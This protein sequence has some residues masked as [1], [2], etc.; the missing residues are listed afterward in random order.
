MVRVMMIRGRRTINMI[1]IKESTVAL[2]IVYV[3]SEIEYEK[4][5]WID[6]GKLK[7]LN[8]YEKPQPVWE[9]I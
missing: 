1:G 6:L 3:I 5:K 2:T 7:H 8:V 9:R 4:S